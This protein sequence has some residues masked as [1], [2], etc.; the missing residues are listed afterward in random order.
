MNIQYIIITAIA[1]F[2][3]GFIGGW[4]VE[5]QRMQLAIDNDL[6][7]RQQASISFI[8]E[9]AKLQTN[10][11][12]FLQSKSEEYEKNRSV[13]TTWTGSV[14]HAKSA[15][16]NV[17]HNRP[18]AS[19]SSKTLDTCRVEL[20]AAKELANRVLFALT[21]SQE[22]DAKFNEGVEELNKRAQ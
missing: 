12:K 7:K 22:R 14:Q 21:V 10:I 15:V 11:Q 9:S 17:P 3:L 19:Q 6:Q 20:F 4:Y 18:T 13:F 16:T 8:Q 1:S 2:F 5:G